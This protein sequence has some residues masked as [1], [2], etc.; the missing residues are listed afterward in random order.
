MLTVLSLHDERHRLFT[1][2][3]LVHGQRAQRR[4]FI[5]Q[6]QFVNGDLPIVAR[7][8]RLRLRRYAAACRVRRLRGRVVHIQLLLF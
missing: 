7:A 4:R 5:K 6:L 8:H 1:Q 3:D 2:L